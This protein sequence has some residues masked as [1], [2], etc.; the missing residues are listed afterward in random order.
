MAGLEVATTPC[1]TAGRVRPPALLQPL[2]VVASTPKQQASK[3]GGSERSPRTV[4]AAQGGQSKG[5]GK[6]KGQKGQPAPSG[7]KVGEVV[8]ELEGPP[9]V[10]TEGLPGGRV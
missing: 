4:W 9:G 7:G 3:E 5:K 10:G 2:L 8:A 6:G 1:L